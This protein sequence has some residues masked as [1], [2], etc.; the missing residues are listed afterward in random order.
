MAYCK[1][2]DSDPCNDSTPRCDD[3]GIHLDT[4]FQRIDQIIA[5]NGNKAQAQHDTLFG[6]AVGN[7]AVITTP[8]RCSQ[9]PSHPW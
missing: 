8:D 3:A 4:M 5:R 2:C 7:L 6:L 9:G 1:F